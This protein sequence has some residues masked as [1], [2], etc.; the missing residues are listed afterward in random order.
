MKIK[1]TRTVHK[2]WNHTQEILHNKK[3]I[4]D[5]I[6][7]GYTR[8]QILETMVCFGK[9]QYTYESPKGK[10]SMIQLATYVPK[11][12]VWEIHAFENKKLFTDCLRFETKKEAEKRIEELLNPRR[13]KYVTKEKK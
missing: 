12:W 3:F 9:Y 11:G 5:M 13:I 7:K 10:I 4:N 1:K 2:M 6:K 8:E